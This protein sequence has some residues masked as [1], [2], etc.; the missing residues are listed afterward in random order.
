MK[1]ILALALLVLA[2]AVSLAADEASR[3]RYAEVFRRF[4]F[5]EEVF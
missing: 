5:P 4:D 2:P 3:K 1:N